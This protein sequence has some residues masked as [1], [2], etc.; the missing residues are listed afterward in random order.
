MRRRIVLFSCALALIAP[1]ARAQESGI[2]A[3][4]AFEKLKGLAG[5]YKADIDGG[6]G[7][8]TP[9]AGTVAFRV[10]GGGSALVEEQFKGDPHEMVSVYHLDGDDLVMTHYCAAGNQPRLKLDRA[11]STPSEL[12]F[13]FVGGTNVDPEKDM[14]IH[15][16]RF[17]FRDGEPTTS[18]WIGYAGGKPGHTAKF[19][20]RKE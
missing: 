16:A 2:S 17:V 14:H 3:K 6:D 15:A 5:E 11:K 1:V 10:V 13:D 9:A 4:D 19:I 7:H 20:L 8:V 12:V 18:Y